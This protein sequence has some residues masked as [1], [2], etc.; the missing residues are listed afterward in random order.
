MV[1]HFKGL[2]VALRGS[3][4]PCK[5]RL[6]VYHA[7]KKQ[8]GLVVSRF[9]S[10]HIVDTTLFTIGNVTLSLNLNGQP[11]KCA[12]VV[13]FSTPSGII[14]VCNNKLDNVKL[15]N[16][17]E[18]CYG[19]VSID[20]N[21]TNYGVC[22]SD[23]TQS[24]KKM[25]AVVCRE[26]GCGEVLDV[27]QGSSVPNGL[28]SNVDC[29]GDEE[30]LWHCLANREKTL[31]RG[32]KVICSEE[33][34]KFFEGYSSC[35]R[36]V[37]IELF[38]SEPPNIML[39]ENCTGSVLID[40]DNV[41]A[42][43]WSDHMSHNLCNSLN[44]GKA[45]KYWGTTPAKNCW[46]FSCTGKE[47]SVWQCSSKKE[48]CE[49]ILY[50]TCE[51]GVK[52]SSTEKCGGK[53]GVRYKEQ[54][55]YVCEDLNEADAKKVC[56]VLKCNDSQEL[57]DEQKMAKEIKV[58]IKCSPNHY[59]VSQC[60]QYPKQC[61]GEPAK[62]KCEGYIPKVEFSLVSLI[63]GLLGA[64]LG[65]VILILMWMNRKRLRLA[66]LSERKASLLDHDK[67]DRD[68]YEDVDSLMEKSA[69]EEDDYRKRGSSGTEYDDIEGQAN[70]ISP[71]ETHH[72]DNIDLP[73]L[74]KRPE[75]ILDYDTYEVE[76]EKQEDYDDVEPIEDASNENA[77][78]TGTQARLDVDSDAGPGPGADAM[79]VTAEVEVHAQPEY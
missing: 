50:V 19:D 42:S 45:I 73:L 41:C 26:L 40:K 4:S 38:D 54:W 20:V 28:L 14:G 46:H 35:N 5:G 70:G 72:D 56:G 43:H 31:C 48:P 32:T 22:Y 67:F 62:I 24:R 37:F 51:E 47:T 1:S 57:L 8:W 9:E 77:G 49:K 61:K 74:P 6:E 71:S 68:N 25:G 39:S 11:K 3:D 15:R 36:S 52:F 64:V 30:S 29:Q 21:G 75:N 69:G 34:L 78:T 23:Q 60:I 79:L 58:T 65:L 53:L 16:F 12:G 76:M 27:K 13:E 59:R 17:T 2:N 66:Y 33:E 18:T 10:V 44:C 55:E 7:D 63:L